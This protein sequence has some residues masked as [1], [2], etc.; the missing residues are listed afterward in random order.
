MGLLHG[1]DAACAARSGRFGTLA[2]RTRGPRVSRAGPPL[3]RAHERQLT[4]NRSLREILVELAVHTRR[5]LL[6]VR[7][8][9]GYNLAGVRFWQ[10]ALEDDTTGTMAES[11]PAT[12]VAG[13]AAFAKQ[14]EAD[15]E[16]AATG[17]VAGSGGG[18]RQRVDAGED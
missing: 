9:A 11:D 7:D 4:A 12:V 6:D 17:G 5:R 14:A 10:A 13:A 15:A 8:R 2:W 1:L 16:A 18:K 3:L